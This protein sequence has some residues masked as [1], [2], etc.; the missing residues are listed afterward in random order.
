MCQQVLADQNK[1][2]TIILYRQHRQRIP[3]IMCQYILPDDE[4]QLDDVVDISSAGDVLSSS[5]GVDEPDICLPH[6]ETCCSHSRNLL[7]T[8]DADKVSDTAYKR[9]YRAALAKCTAIW[10]ATHRSS[11][12]S[13]AVKSITD[14]AIIT[15]GATRW[16]SQYDALKQLLQIGAK[17]NDVCQALN[18]PQFKK[19]ELECLNEYV[20]V[21]SPVAV[22]LDKLQGEKTAYFGNTLPTLLMLM[23]KLKAMQNKIFANCEPL[24]AALLAGMERRFHKE[25]SLSG[26]VSDNIVAAI[27][28]AYFKMRWL[29]DDK[30]DSCRELFIQSVRNFESS[31]D[32]SSCSLQTSRE[33]EDDFFD[34]GTT[35]STDAASNAIDRECINYLS[36]TDTELKM[37]ARYSRIRKVFIKYNTSLPSSAPVERLFSTAGQIEVPRRNH[38]SDSMKLLLLKANQSLF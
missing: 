4:E 31:L 27:S 10:N 21:I 7:A 22:A 16:N 5:D 15:P 36:D 20:S 30:K 13:D 29:P 25:L 24:V 28:H 34:Y 37:L 6:H 38:L 23:T 32:S 19:S 1:K 33:V 11:K 14:K 26:S 35:P 18:T 2:Q 9:V 8:V 12:A 17:L 3:Q